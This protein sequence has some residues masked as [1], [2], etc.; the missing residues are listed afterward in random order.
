VLEDE[1]PE[2]EEEEP[3][4]TAALVVVPRTGRA[5]PEEELAASANG[6]RPPVAED[7]ELLGDVE[8][9]PVELAEEDLEEGYTLEDEDEEVTEEEE[10][11][12]SPLGTST[13]ED[14]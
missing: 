2:E 9:E 1:E 10:E 4:D 12:D 8:E 5:E 3:D 7:A 6:I 14:F 13:D 11:D